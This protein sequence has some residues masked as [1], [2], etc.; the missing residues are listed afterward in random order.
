[1][2]SNI[3]SIIYLYLLLVYSLKSRFGNY[4]VFFFRSVKMSSPMLNNV[5]SAG[6]F[7]MYSE[8]F[9]NAFDYIHLVTMGTDNNICMVSFNTATFRT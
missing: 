8:V 3:S 9:M 5:I 6:C 7:L 2:V 1:M 4:S